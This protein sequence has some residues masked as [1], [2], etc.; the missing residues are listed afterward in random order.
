MEKYRELLKISGKD[1][2]IE[3][4]RLKNNNSIQELNEF[5]K[6]NGIKEIYEVDFMIYLLL[7]NQTLRE[8]K[9]SEIHSLYHYMKQNNDYVKK[10]E[11]KKNE[12][13]GNIEFVID[14][15]NCEVRT[16]VLSDVIPGLLNYF[17]EL[18]TEDRANTCFANSRNLSMVL[19]YEY[20]NDVVTGICYG[21]TDKSEYLH[22]WVETEIYGDEV[23][24]DFTMNAIINKEGYY[25]LRHVKELERISSKTIMEDNKNYGKAIAEIDAASSFY[26]IFR[27]EYIRDLQKN[28]KI[29]RNK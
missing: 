18:A 1:I 9:E 21:A 8:K 23:V 25:K 22:S 16:M 24:L 10:M 3:Y 20:D 5:I 28:D 11:F 12:K 14:T 4:S 7:F 6:K 26:N 15:T 27:N 2:D 13:W 29:T 19:G 17:P